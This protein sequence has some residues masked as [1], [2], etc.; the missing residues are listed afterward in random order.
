M[1]AGDPATVNPAGTVAVDA[2]PPP[3][4][5]SPPPPGHSTPI[6]GDAPAAAAAA[7]HSCPIRAAAIGCQRT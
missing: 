6:A 4:C 1:P 5:P 3:G 2:T 7:G